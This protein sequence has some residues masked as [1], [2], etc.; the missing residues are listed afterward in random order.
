MTTDTLAADAMAQF[1]ALVLADSALAQT[2]NGAEDAGRLTELALGHA[3][4]HG[5][6]LDAAALRGAIH[7]DPLAIMRWQT[8]V[9]H[10]PR[11]P[12]PPWLPIQASAVDGELVIDWAYFGPDPLR[13]SFFEDSI[14][15]A[16]RRPFNRMLTYRTTLADFLA[17][18]GSNASLAPDGF[19]FHMSRCGSTLVSQMLAALPQNIAIS[20]AAPID[21]IVQL[22]RLWPALRPEQH[23]RQ[24][25]A[26]VAAFGRKRSGAERHFFI[27]LDSWHALALP[28]FRKA[29]PDVP[30]LFLYRDPVEVMVSQSRQPGMQMVPGILPPRV[31]GIDDS[32][33]LL[34]DEYAARVLAKVCEAA[35]GGGGLGRALFVNYRDL[36]DAFWSKILPHFGVSF[37]AEDCDTMRQAAR[38]DAKAPHFEFTGDISA[39]QSEA[40]GDMRA[41]ADI[42]LGGVYRRLEEL[43][44]RGA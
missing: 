9:L 35:A 21:A 37:S 25:A 1:G 20:E 39:K 16:M 14:R 26:M 28:L 17:D 8:K 2:L 32:G 5:I 22:S 3:R 29:F 4:R 13:Q 11:W 23:A 18:A 43:S 12:P 19:I 41:L 36:P 38:Y 34:G 44:V 27:K 6:A 42:H 15:Q 24:L 30:W 7:A 10:V 31:Y 33:S 40:S